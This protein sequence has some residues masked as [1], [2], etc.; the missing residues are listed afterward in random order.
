VSDVEQSTDE[1]EVL[2]QFLDEYRHVVAAKVAGLSDADAR[3]AVVASGLSPLG[4]LKHLAWVEYGWFRYRFAG[5]DVPDTPRVDG[6]NAVQFATEETD[7][8]EDVLARYGDACD[9]SRAIAASA[10]TLDELA[11]RH[12]P[13]EVPATLR[14][15]YVH[16]IEET[17]RHAGHLDIMREQIDGATG[18]G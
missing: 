11:R 1:R 8:V 17:A 13:G 4:V 2:V 10:P 6:D 9:R 18:D 12:R 14:W 16:M 15:I 5:E 7:T 3:R